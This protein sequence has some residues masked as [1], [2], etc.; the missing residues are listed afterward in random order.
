MTVGDNTKIEWTRGAD[1]SP[2]ATWNPLIGCSR[3]GGPGD[4]CANCYAIGVVHRGMAEQH[5]GLTVKRPGERT[6][7]TGEVREVPHV[8]EQ[9]LRW[10]RPRRVFVNSLSDL[11]HPEVSELFIARVFAVMSLAPQHTFQILTKR[12]KAMA[13][14][15]NSDEWRYKVALERRRLTDTVAAVQWPLPNVW[16]GVSIEHNKYAWR[17]DYL[18][19]TPAAVR[20]VSAEPLLGPLD[21]LD[22]TG[23]SWVVVGGESGPGARPM[24]PDWVEDLLLETRCDNCHDGSGFYFDGD[25]EEYNC[26]DHRHR[27]AFFFKQYG[28]WR[29]WLDPDDSGVESR[30]VWLHADGRTVDEPGAVEPG[31]SWVKVWR[32]GKRRAGRH[33]TGFTQPHAGWLWLDCEKEWNEY[34]D[35]GHPYQGLTTPSS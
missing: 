24:H 9:P 15:L 5:R 8:L 27:A 6:D 23:I 35:D 18:R 29:W 17:A 30:R 26:P 14:V 7:W 32:L 21:K 22:L 13:A 1:G 2:G 28:D 10:Q 31:G 16:L 34:P 4:G 11:F 20:W 3:V 25:G 19:A 33:L 12:S